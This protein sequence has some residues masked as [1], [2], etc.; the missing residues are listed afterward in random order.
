MNNN[1][2]FCALIDTPFT[3]PGDQ[4]A[5]EADFSNRDNGLIY[6]ANSSA[7]PGAAQSQK[8]DF[9]HADRADPNQLNLILWRDAMGSRPPPPM[10]SAHAARM[11]DE[12][13]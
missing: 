10:L 11:R 3:G 13:D 2:A 9:R 5:F 6:A 1:D 7:A 12:D 8:M 4:P